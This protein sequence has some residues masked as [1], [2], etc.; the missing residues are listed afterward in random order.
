VDDVV[1]ALDES[2]RAASAGVAQKL[3]RAGRSVELVLE[4]K[5]M[6]W[7]FKVGI[8]ARYCVLTP[9]YNIVPLI[10]SPLHCSRVLAQLMT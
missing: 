2:L 5:K 8:F 9:C 6:K 4:A 7:A 1:V 3:R 10:C